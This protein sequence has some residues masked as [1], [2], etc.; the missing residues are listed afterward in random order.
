MVWVGELLFA[1]SLRYRVLPSFEEYVYG[2]LDLGDHTVVVLDHDVLVFVS[3]DHLDDALFDVLILD[4]FERVHV[5]V[6]E[7]DSDGFVVAFGDHFE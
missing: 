3:R 2:V 1:E 6:A 7:I 4:Q 5:L